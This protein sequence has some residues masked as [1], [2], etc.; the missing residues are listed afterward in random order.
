MNRDRIS[1]WG[2]RLR[3]RAPLLGGWLRRSAC[4]RLAEDAGPAAVP[5]LAAALASRD[6]KVRSIAEAAL[7]ALTNPEAVDGLCAAWA[8]DRD[9]RL[10]T[11]VAE[12]GYVAQSPVAVRVL[13]ALQAGRNE[14]AGETAAAIGPLLALARNAKDPLRPHTAAALRSLTNPEA[15]DAL[16]AA[17][18]KERDEQLGTIVA[19]CGYVAR[20]PVDVRVLSSLQAGRLGDAGDSAAAIGPL[21][22]VAQ[23]A[24]DP[25]RPDAEAALQSLTN[26]EAVDALCAAWAKDRDGQIGAIIA[27]R[28]YVA[29]EPLEVKLATL[30]KTGKAV[31]LGRGTVKALPLIVELLRDADPQ[32]SKGAGTF[33]R[34]IRSSARVDALCEI[35]IADPDGPAAAVVKEKGCQPRSVSRRCVL[36]LVT[37]QVDRY[38]ELDFE[39][40]HLRA[41]YHAADE[42]LRQ[43]I[44]EVVRQTGD[45]RLLG[46]F[47]EVRRRK[48]AAELTED[49]AAV[50]LDVHARNRQWPEIFSLLFHVPLSS[51]VAALD[52]LSESGWRPGNEVE[53]ALL[54]EL[55]ETRKAV[56]RIPE[57]APQ[58][59]VNLG[60]A[61]RK[62][63]ERGRG[64]DVAGRAEEDLR[65]DLAE[66]APPEAVAALAALATTGRTTSK[67]IRRARTHA[68]WLVRIAWLALCEIAPQFAVS[69]APTGGKGGGM[70]IKRLAPSV[71]DAAIYRRRAMSLNP[72]QL[73]ALQL[74]LAGGR[75]GAPP[76]KKRRA[77]GQRKGA[78]SRRSACGRVLEVLARYHLRHTIEVDET[79]TVEISETTI[80]IE[81]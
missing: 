23:D 16:C 81:G 60:S 56:G 8:K 59:G 33:L 63:I 67:D 74:A 52:V 73:A 31:R 26:P 13:S 21:L 5:H 39:F 45:A 69:D 2:R 10:G 37:G 1:K 64:G 68:H 61:M 79:M 48:L 76:S 54:E 50:V 25:L 44:G 36:F 40:Q 77:K 58:P 75:D 6:A 19:E 65:R 38:F 42:G 62:W 72:D 32:V 57:R 47:R 53:A 14:A 28:G 70:W 71:L 3:S 35:A 30:F 7:R 51:V 12:C 4:R 80:E 27:E 24:R 34:K 18:A 41:E 55:L 49:E 9:E 15:V 46:L 29:R 66:A 20:G 43:R 78:A 22:G 11:I 17:W